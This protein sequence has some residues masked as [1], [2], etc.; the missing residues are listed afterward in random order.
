MPEFS[1]DEINLIYIFNGGVREWVIADLKE[2]LLSSGSE[3][4]ELRVLIEGALE[5]LENMTDAAFCQMS[6]ELVPDFIKDE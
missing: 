5:K 3:D 2:L 1:P 4:A 6:K